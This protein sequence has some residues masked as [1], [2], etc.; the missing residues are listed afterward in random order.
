MAAMADLFGPRSSARFILKPVAIVLGALLFAHWWA[1]DSLPRYEPAFLADYW[2]PYFL[3]PLEWLAAAGVGYYWYQRSYWQPPDARA[4]EPRLVLMVAG[5]IGVFIVSGQIILGMFASF[6]HSPFAHS[7]RWLLT[8]MFFAGSTLLAVETGRAVLLRSLGRYS[9]TG[10]LVFTTVVL[11]AVQLAE[12]QFMKPGL[13]D[14]AKFWGSV[15]IPLAAIGL[16]TGFFVL[17]GGLKAGLLVATPIVAFQY[18]SPIL[19]V[20]DWPMVALAG[21]GAPAVGLWIAEGL[22]A[23]EEEQEEETG[24]RLP[25]VAWTVTGTLALV[26]FWF[27]FG[28]FGYRP[29]FVP[30]GSMTPVIHQGD[31]VLLGPVNPE[32]VKVGD[33]VLYQQSNRERI[34]HRVVDIVKGENG[35]REFVFK[36]DANNT[37]D[38]LPVADKQLIGELVLKVPKIGWLPIRF[39]QELQKLR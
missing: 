30:S 24:I 23:E 21:V 6:G 36:G 15:F 9:L 13:V 22:F 35:D 5:L 20:A 10:A 25:S 31:V 37:T 34:L 27:S 38:P 28:F 3:G 26:I 16:V 17:Y 39:Q 2:G 19:P 33:V 7:P 18:F 8:N 12:S 29:V 32:Q 14:Q 1:F 4:I 11:V